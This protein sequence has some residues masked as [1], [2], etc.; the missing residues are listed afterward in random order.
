MSNISKLCLVILICDVLGCL[1]NPTGLQDCWLYGKMSTCGW[2]SPA[3]P[4][5]KGDIIRDITLPET[6]SNLRPE[7]GWLQDYSWP[8][9]KGSLMLV[10]GRVVETCCDFFLDLFSTNFHWIYTDP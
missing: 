4:G 10:S 5:K 3:A 1:L 2:Q 8:I 7:I 9:F 6:N